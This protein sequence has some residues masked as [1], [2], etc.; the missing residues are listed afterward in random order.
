MDRENM[1]EHPD[2]RSISAYIDR[3]LDQEEHDEVER[4]L[5]HCGAC[6]DLLEEF[7][8]LQENA[9]GL[10]DQLPS[11]D[12]WPGIARAIHQE[13]GRDPSD[14]D[15]IRL[16]PRVAARKP[17]RKIRLSVPQAAAAGLILALA[18][19][20]L[21][22]AIGQSSVDAPSGLAAVESPVSWVALVGEA[23]PD[24]SEAAAEVAELERVLAEQGEALDPETRATLE[25][26]LLTIDR[27]IRVAC[28]KSLEA[29]VVM[30]PKKISSEARPPSAIVI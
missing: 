27:A 22:A 15:V 18:S 29:P 10:A 13:A 6:S 4:H 14:P 9:R 17:R 7:R 1:M 3:D 23:R 19:G 16:H 24:L 28:C 5:A 26:N 20:A 30:R 2:P 11:R 25:K 12:L 21:G 8:E